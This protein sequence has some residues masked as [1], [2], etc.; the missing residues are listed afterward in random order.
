MASSNPL[1]AYVAIVI[2]V[3]EENADFAFLTHEGKHNK[4]FLPG[5]KIENGETR[6]EAA[7][8]ELRE[9]TGLKLP[10]GVELREVETFELTN[11]AGTPMAVCS[12]FAADVP[13][14][15]FF[16]NY[17]SEIEA[18]DMAR[19]VA[20]QHEAVAL[21]TLSDGTFQCPI[22][23]EVQ[24]K[25]YGY[26]ARVT[27]RDAFSYGK[28][29]YWPTLKRALEC[30]AFDAPFEGYHFRYNMTESPLW[31]KAL[32]LL[33]DNNK[34]DVILKISARP[35]DT[36]GS[37]MNAA[38][39]K[40]LPKMKD[41]SGKD[42]KTLLQRLKALEVQLT[43]R[44]LNLNHK[45]TV[46]FVA[47]LFTDELAEWWA[48]TGSKLPINSIPA[49]IENIKESFSLKDFEGEHLMGLLDVHQDG[50]SQVSL[51]NYIRYFN[52]YSADWK[53]DASFRMMAL[54]FIRGLSDANIRGEMLSVYRKEPFLTELPEHHRMPEL[55][56]LCTKSFLN[57]KDFTVDNGRGK[58]KA[59]SSSANGKKS[60]DYDNRSNQQSKKKGKKPKT[61]SNGGGQFKSQNGKNKKTSSDPDIEA[62]KKH[63]TEKE[64][65]DCFKEGRCLICKK[66]GHLLKDCP[67]KGN[68]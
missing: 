68:K 16:G 39:I 65:S 2:R 55:Q 30:D 67:E 10:A 29:A 1:P 44:G 58:R 31:Q 49:L 62:A 53:V 9:E 47:A 12:I 56:R 19:Q 5:G 54:I 24:T 11:N 50:N 51:S 3:A 34:L 41:I 43:Q 6:L 61:S 45:N 14:A 32:D 25:F 63:L 40:H 57:R 52:K 42:E 7:N 17:R 38:L 4:W 22:C 48:D 20:E 28:L 26:F 36:I 37:E 15:D 13:F 60:N 18:T 64:I 23:P 21:A 46:H 59:D 66:K 27:K 8:R 35:L 33:M